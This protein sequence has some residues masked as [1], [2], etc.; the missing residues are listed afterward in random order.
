[1]GPD[2]LVWGNVQLCL[3]YNYDEFITKWTRFT[4][5]Q[6]TQWLTKVVCI[7]LALGLS[8]KADT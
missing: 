4:Q 1:V 6:A 2:L 8:R 3:V 7:I 5:A